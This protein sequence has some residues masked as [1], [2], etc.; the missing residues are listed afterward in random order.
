[1]KSTHQLLA[2]LTVSMLV[3][4][5]AA[6]ASAA[7]F[8]YSAILDGRSESPTNASPGT[9]FAM[10]D[11]DDHAHTLR[12]QISFSGLL[13]NT[14]AA[15]IHALTAARLNGTAGIATTVPN[16]AGFPVAV[17]S[18]TYSNTLD[19]T[20]ASSYNPAFINNQG[21]TTASA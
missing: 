10:V 6:T 13:G 4:A 19:L 20:L 14:T 12:L 5:L 15:H 17:N 18:G 11:Y 21:G 3:T 8:S 2:A 16:F 7:V 9:G 1:M